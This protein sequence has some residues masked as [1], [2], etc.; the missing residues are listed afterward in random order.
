MTMFMKIVKVCVVLTLILVVVFSPFM[1]IIWKE[2][3]LRDLSLLRESLNSELLHLQSKTATLEINIEQLSA[4]ERLERYVLD[5]L[6]MVRPDP[7]KIL[8]VERDKYGAV[9]ISRGGFK[10]FLEKLMGLQ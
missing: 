8:A 7:V 5:T 10:G 6:G 1:L 9:L 2:K 4:S 3:Q